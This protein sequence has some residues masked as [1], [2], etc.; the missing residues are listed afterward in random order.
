MIEAP[1]YSRDYVRLPRTVWRALM[2]DEVA[3]RVYLL[4]LERAAYKAGPRII[5]GRRFHVELGQAVCGRDELATELATTPRKIR[6]ALDRLSYLGI[7]AVETTKLGTVVTLLGLSESTETPD[8]ERPSKR[9][10][11]DHQT[12]K[13]RPS[14]DQETTTNEDLRREEGKKERRRSASRVSEDALRL[15]QLLHELIAKRSPQLTIAK[16]T[17]SERAKE[18]QRWAID[19]DKLHRID[20]VS[21][22]HIERVIRWCQADSFWHANILSGRSLRAKYNTLEAQRARQE[23]QRARGGATLQAHNGYGRAEPA[24]AQE[25]AAYVGRENPFS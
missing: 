14:N 5:G 3:L 10:T 12:T 4:L 2:H 24:T 25:H 16:H 21:L 15:A 13:R 9:P 7:S 17:E 22:E 8:A 20:G 18:C 23:A 19:I 1:D 11:G 6:T